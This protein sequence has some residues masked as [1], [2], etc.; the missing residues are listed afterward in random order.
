MGSIDFDNNEVSK[1]S[2][3]NKTNTFGSINEAFEDDEG[4]LEVKSSS[5]VTMEHNNDI[6]SRE[7]SLS[8]IIETYIT[9]RRR[10]SAEMIRQSRV[11]KRFSRALSTNFTVQPFET[12]K[13]EG[14]TETV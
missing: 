14:M 5:K 13:L 4:N 10:S 11:Y 7:R 3:K 8:Q 6:H 2:L 12:Y 9:E 1:E